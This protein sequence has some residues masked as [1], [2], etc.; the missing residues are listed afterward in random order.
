MQF[1]DEPKTKF[2][3]PVRT[4]TWRF[5]LPAGPFCSPWCKARAIPRWLRMPL[6]VSYAAAM[7][8]ENLHLSA[9]RS[10]RALRL[11]LIPLEAYVKNQND[12]Y[13][14]RL[15]HRSWVCTK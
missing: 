9:E 2:C 12:R 8:H 5:L 6:K 11:P 4:L 3:H 13:V 1:V 14:F 10:G 7:F 15:L